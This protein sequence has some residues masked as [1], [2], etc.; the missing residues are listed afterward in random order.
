[1]C[2]ALGLEVE[3]LVRTSFGPVKLGDLPAGETRALTTKEI[4]ILEAL[5]PVS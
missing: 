4:A 1:M 3:R 2:D 5:I